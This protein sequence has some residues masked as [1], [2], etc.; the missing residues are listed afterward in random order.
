MKLLM[1]NIVHVTEELEIN[2]EKESLG[3][4]DII[5]NPFCPSEWYKKF[6]TKTIHNIYCLIRNTI[7]YFLLLLWLLPLA[8]TV[9]ENRYIE[10][11]GTNGKPVKKWGRVN[12]LHRTENR[13]KTVSM[14]NR[15]T[16]GGFGFSKLTLS[17]LKVKCD[18]LQPS[19]VF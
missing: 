15:S 11:K 5:P 2:A 16:S 4:S 12:Q 6:C 1:Q 14:I 7:K 10:K 3:S 9:M 18:A 8:Q 17:Q 13:S 19:G